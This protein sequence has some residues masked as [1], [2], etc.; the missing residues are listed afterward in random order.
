MTETH[1]D[2]PVDVELARRKKS[3]QWLSRK[4]GLHSK[5]I[6]RALNRQGLPSGSVIDAICRALDWS[7]LPSDFFDIPKGVLIDRAKGLMSEVVDHV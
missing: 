3:R 4:A 1:I 6:A 5:T 7:V 2:H